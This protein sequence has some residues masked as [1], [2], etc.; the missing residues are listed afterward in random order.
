MPLPAEA[1]AQ[2]LEL[3]QP[4]DPPRR[5]EFLAAVE[6]RLDGARDRPRNRAPG[7]ARAAAAVF[8]RPQPARRPDRAA[9]LAADLCH[10]IA[11]GRGGTR[12]YSV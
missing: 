11:T 9:G 4:I 1:R 8:R 2:I 10:R 6:Q 7:R 5:E 3:A 12:R